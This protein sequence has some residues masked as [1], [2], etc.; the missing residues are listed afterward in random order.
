M[1]EP[2]W[3]SVLPPILAIGLAI[4]TRQ[5][6]MS[7]AGGLWLAWTILEGWNPL[8]GLAQT[9]EGTVAVLGGFDELR[10]FFWT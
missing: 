1:S 5:V 2:T 9:I 8:T 3:I 4:W 7:L 6:Y 10:E